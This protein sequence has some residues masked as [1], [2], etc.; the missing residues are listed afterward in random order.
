MHHKIT[1]YFKYER[2]TWK[3][4]CYASLMILSSKQN[5]PMAELLI[6][7]SSTI[8][9]LALD[10]TF[11][12]RATCVWESWRRHI[13]PFPILFSCRIFFK[14]KVL[15]ACHLFIKKSIPILLTSQTGAVLWSASFLLNPISNIISVMRSEVQPPEPRDRLGESRRSGGGCNSLFPDLCGQTEQSG[16]RDRSKWPRIKESCWLGSTDPAWWRYQQNVGKWS[17]NLPTTPC[18]ITDSLIY[19]SSLNR[20]FFF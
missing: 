9:P 3:K 2:Q 12:E 7:S 14:M 6:P 18:L 4:L 1:K 11:C 10:P 17:E 20:S 16:R 13:W 19:W 15:L 8:F 5:Q